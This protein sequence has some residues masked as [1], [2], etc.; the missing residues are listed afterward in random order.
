M[1]RAYDFQ[2]LLGAANTVNRLSAI[3]YGSNGIRFGRAHNKMTNIWAKLHKFEEDKVE[4]DLGDYTTVS[5][6]REVV[7]ALKEGLK[8]PQKM[9]NSLNMAPSPQASAKNKVWFE[10]PWTVELADTTSFAFFAVTKPIRGEDGDME[11]M[12]E[13]IRE[14]EQELQRTTELH[15]LQSNGLIDMEEDMVDDGVPTIAVVESETRDIILEVLSNHEDHVSYRAS[16]E[17]FVAFAEFDGNRIFKSTLVGQLN[18]NPFLSKDRLTQVK[19]QCT[20]IIVKITY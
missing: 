10:K 9:L 16:S 1:E 4:P 19:N 6:N 2:E 14:K 13:D 17:K 3:E 11:V 8:E 20:S 7:T 15:D 18:G 5:S 12:R